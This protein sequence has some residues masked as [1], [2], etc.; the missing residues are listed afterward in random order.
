LRK[1]KNSPTVSLSSWVDL[2]VGEWVKTVLEVKGAID[3]KDVESAFRDTVILRGMDTNNYVNRDGYRHLVEAANTLLVQ[4]K[5]DLRVTEETARDA[6]LKGL[7]QHLPK[8]RKRGVISESAII[9]RAK[10]E[11]RGIKFADGN[12][13]FPVRL[14]PLAKKTDFAIGPIR[15]LS[16]VLFLREFAPNL[17]KTWPKSE[18]L[19]RHL[20]KRWVLHLKEHDH[21]ILVEMRGFEREMAWRM[22]RECAEFSLNLVR[23]LFRFGRTSR[24]RLGGEFAVEMNQSTAILE[25]GGGVWFSASTG[26]MA[27]VLEDGWLEVFD[28]HLS[29]FSSTLASYGLW[30]ASGTHS[31]NPITERLRYSHRLIAEAYSEPSDYLRLVRLIS[32]LEALALLEG[33]DKAHQLASRCASAGGWGDTNRAIE[34]FDAVGFAYR[35]RNAVVH[36][37][38]PGFGD[39]RTAFFG[40]EKYLLYIVLGFTAL[41]AEISVKKRPQS[42]RQLRRELAR[43]IDLF[44]WEPN[45]AV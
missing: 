25:P 17:R 35:W 5:L 11:L 38:A 42:V 28:Q 32:A 40:V 27:S 21:I 16:K 10:V 34:I 41:F 44:F 9:D 31:G 30:L 23:M 29:P 36:G 7:S 20:L 24:I 14:A 2:F 33:N 19:H 3:R 8:A 12:Y 22:A 45:I 1:S 26:G 37:D 4:E 15:I 18:K 43:A 6:I 13:A 39:V